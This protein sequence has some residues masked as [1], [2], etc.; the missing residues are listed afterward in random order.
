MIDKSQQTL[1][2]IMFNYTD[3]IK[4][5]VDVAWRLWQAA[6]IRLIFLIFSLI[7]LSVIIGLIL[8]IGWLISGVNLHEIT[9]IANYTNIN[10]LT[11][12]FL[13]KYFTIAIVSIISLLFYSMIAITIAI[14]I[15]SGSFGCIALAIKDPFYKFK[16]NDFL[17]L[18]RKT[19]FPMIWFTT[20]ITIVG[21]LIDIVF[22]LDIWLAYRIVNDVN[23]P[24]LGYIVVM[25]TI[26]FNVF[27]II[28]MIS[29]TFYGIASIYLKGNRAKLAFSDA[30][31]FIKKRPS[32]IWFI[33]IIGV[34]Y[35]LLNLVFIMIS[36]IIAKLP[37]IGIYISIPFDIIIFFI[38][39]VL[40]IALF[41]SIFY[42]FG[43]FEGLFIDSQTQPSEILLETM[44]QRL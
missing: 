26:I 30:F 12:L 4:V 21:I 40:N 33:F 36:L 32:S 18:A 25:L 27:L 13:S 44:S 7:G 20:L 41:G 1:P 19:F 43:Y 6:F 23:N 29:L 31:D 22:A 34:F 8:I 17:S 5:G 2:Q 42:Y 16:W 9:D 10:N 38:Q 11:S 39:S 15:Y 35:A 37:T 3:T 14:Y 24:F 28:M